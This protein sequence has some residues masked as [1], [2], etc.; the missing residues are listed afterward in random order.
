MN[1]KNLE[2]SVKAALECHDRA[3]FQLRGLMNDQAGADMRTVRLN[4]LDAQNW[5]EAN[6][7]LG[8]P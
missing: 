1:L 6:K 5:I 7:G 3:Y 8:Q 2:I 4:L